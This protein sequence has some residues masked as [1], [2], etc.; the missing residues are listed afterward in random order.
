M[1]LLVLK[2]QNQ[3]SVTSSNVI[4]FISEARNDVN[5]AFVLHA[6]TSLDHNL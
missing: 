5:E 4:N 2:L 6:F 3:M 1:D